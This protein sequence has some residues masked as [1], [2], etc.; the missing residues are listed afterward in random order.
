MTLLCAQDGGGGGGGL[1]EC[2]IR[3]TLVA[4]ASAARRRALSTY[5]A[6][7]HLEKLSGII[8]VHQVSGRF[9]NAAA[10][11]AAAEVEWV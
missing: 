8:I 7:S 5:Y 3:A 10:A 2:G 6:P 9:V 11:A 4:A 1:F